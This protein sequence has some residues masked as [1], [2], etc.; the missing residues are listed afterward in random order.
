MKSFIAILFI[1]LLPLILVWPLFKAE[2]KKRNRDKKLNSLANDLTSKPSETDYLQASQKNTDR[3]NKAI[4]E[5]EKS[6]R[7]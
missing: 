4:N 2:S 6:K 1:C 3:L 5:I 7:N